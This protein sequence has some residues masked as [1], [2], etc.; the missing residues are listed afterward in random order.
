MSSNGVCR[1]HN[2]VFDQLAG[3]GS[4][5]TSEDGYNQQLL[6]YPAGWQ[7]GNWS[8]SCQRAFWLFRN[9]TSSSLQLRRCGRGKGS[10]RCPSLLNLSLHNRLCAAKSSPSPGVVPE[11]ETSFSLPFRPPSLTASVRGGRLWEQLLVGSREWVG[12]RWEYDFKDVP[13]NKTL[14]KTKTQIY[15]QLFESKSTSL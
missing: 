14:D 10:W 13:T 2:V 6:V 15:L 4:L 8:A 9:Q 1:C 5:Y 3:E 11:R 12:D 7:Q